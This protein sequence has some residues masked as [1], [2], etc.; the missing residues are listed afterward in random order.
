MNQEQIDYFDRFLDGSLSAQERDA[1]LLQLEN[2]KDFKSD[3]EMHQ[4]LVEGIQRFTIRAEV[5]SAYQGYL[6][7]KFWKFFGFGALIFTVGLFSILNLIPQPKTEAELMPSSSL[8]PTVV[9]DTV[10]RDT[11]KVLDVKSKAEHTRAVD[12]TGTKAESLEA[13]Y[14]S[15]KKKPQ[16]FTIDPTQDTILFCREG[17][18][19]KLEANSLVYLNGKS[20]K[21]KVRF[22]VTEYYSKKDVIQANLGT[23]AGGRLLESGGMLYV[24]AKSGKRKL[25]LQRPMTIAFSGDYAKSGMGA[26]VGEERELSALALERANGEGL[27]ERAGDDVPYDTLIIDEDKQ[28]Y[29]DWQT[30]TSSVVEEQ[31]MSDSFA[32][33]FE[34]ALPIYVAYEDIR[35]GKLDSATEAL[36]ILSG[37]MDEIR[38]TVTFNAIGKIFP[39][40]GWINCDRF[41]YSRKAK[42]NQK[43][44]VK[45][46]VQQKVVLAFEEINSMMNGYVGGNEVVFPSI[47]IGMKVKAVAIAYNNGK[48]Y[49][50]EG[51]GSSSEE[52]IEIT[53]QEMEQEAFDDMLNTFNVRPR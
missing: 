24:E 28:T 14:A 7:L 12:S 10:Q 30:A 2:D 44:L 18:K 35:T 41:Y 1:F 19:I 4:D 32:I 47:P 3:F 51:T 27:S 17:T 8:A 37:M 52:P 15:W 13:L 31:G 50:G 43:V 38:P 5:Q 26:F 42:V 39:R 40:M 46:F 33:E 53:Y 22:N 49:Y 48:Y 34:D 36:L 23:T 16:R 11:M 20:V 29:V 21:N 45:P 6:K 9:V 25:R